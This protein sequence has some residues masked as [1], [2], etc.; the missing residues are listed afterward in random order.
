MAVSAVVLAA[1]LSSRFGRPGG[2]KLIVPVDGTPLVRLSVCA[3]LD[4]RIGD[5]VVVTGAES[6][7]VEHALAG[8]D[9]RLVREP[10]FAD[11]MATSLRRG[12]G[13]VAAGTEAVVVAL[14]DQ[15]F[16]RPEAYRRVV[17]TW[18]DT[19]AP[20]V[21]PRYAD[22]P[23]PAHPVLLSAVVFDELLALRGDVGA[24]QVIAR[25]PARVAVAEMAW[26]APMDVDTPGDLARLTEER[27]PRG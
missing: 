9:V 16:V 7:R 13:A 11:G 19:A 12:I 10:A 27:R 18:R 21:V 2:S 22:H 6:A 3:A 14:G 5:V 4:A 17:Q 24:R 20:I 23:A 15:P 26:D 8:L 25:D 1:G